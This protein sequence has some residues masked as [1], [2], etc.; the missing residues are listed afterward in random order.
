MNQTI[1]RKCQ[2]F[3]TFKDFCHRLIVVVFIKNLSHTSEPIPITTWAAWIHVN[4]YM[5]EEKIPE[6][7]K[8]PELFI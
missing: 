6:L 8:I 7:A 1:P 2:N 5:I 4:P 3:S